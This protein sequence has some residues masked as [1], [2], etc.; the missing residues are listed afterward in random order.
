MGRGATTHI[1]QRIGAAM[2]LLQVKDWREYQGY[3]KRGPHWIKLHT[4]LVRDVAFLSLPIESKAILPFVWIAAADSINGTVPD[5]IPLIAQLTTFPQEYVAKALP[6]LV[7]HF[8]L[9]CDESVADSATEG[10][11]TSAPGRDNAVGRGEKREREEVEKETKKTLNHAAEA[12][13]SEEQQQP[14]QTKNG[15]EATVLTPFDE[16]PE[17]RERAIKELGALCIEVAA[18]EG[19]EVREVLVEASRTSRGSIITNPASVSLEWICQTIARL[20]SK[21]QPIL[22]ENNKRAFDAA[23][24][25]QARLLA[26]QA[27]QRKALTR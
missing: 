17:D 14:G 13:P 2:K 19:K 22:S 23:D 18:R 15:A 9:P 26:A 1:D 6:P 7:G 27:E 8:L 10:S 4:R 5:S 25:V 12:A 16:K 3:K 24:R 20:K 11:R 21:G